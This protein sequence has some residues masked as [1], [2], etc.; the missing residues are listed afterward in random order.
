MT[1]IEAR[2]KLSGFFSPPSCLSI[3]DLDLEAISSRHARY[4]WT[5]HAQYS[6]RAYITMTP[7]NL[8]MTI[9]HIANH[10]Q[11]WRSQG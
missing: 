1:E 8:C 3:F 2:Q 5:S 10:Y 11:D 4:E 7:L 9:H 6:L